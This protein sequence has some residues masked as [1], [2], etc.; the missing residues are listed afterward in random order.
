MAEPNKMETR[1]VL[2]LI[3]SMSVP[4]LISMFMQ[5]SYNFVDCM[6]VSWISEEALTAV[7]LA[8]PI[9]TLMIATSIGL[10]VGTNVLVANHLGRRQFDRANQ[11]AAN[12]IILTAAMGALITCV[13]LAVIEPF[14]S[15]FAEDPVIYEYGMQYM[16]VC[17]FMEVSNMVHIC[18]QK[19]IQGTGNMLAPMGFQ[20]AGVVLNYILDPVL[21]FGRGPFP[22]MGIR[23]AAVATVAGYTFSMLLAFWV[24]LCT[25]Q[26][27]RLSP[28]AF[29]ID[30]HIFRDIFVFGFPSFVMNAL[31]AAMTWFTNLFLAA[32][33]M[34]AVAFFGAY[35]KLQQV[36]VM[37]LNGLV[38]GCIPVMSYNYGAGNKPRLQQALRYGTVI[39]CLLTG[40][41]IVLLWALPRQ[42]LTIFR[43]SDA[44]M[45]FGVPAVRIMSTS[46]VFAAIITMI[47]S[48]MQSTKRVG[49]SLLMNALRQLVI[50]VPMMWLLSRF[51]G[52]DGIWWA[53]P[54]TETVTVLI[55][56]VIHKRHP[57]TMPQ[58]P[59]GGGA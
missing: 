28:R 10:G 17:A 48:Y 43:A 42:I 36:V 14:F 27:V 55:S 56:W 41:S 38:Q 31:G 59:A 30:F 13:V 46:Y 21:I 53:F 5:Y 25:P 33:S 12:A 15:A 39:A 34:T 52:M 9:T 16:R 26:R 8:F 51:W 32:W 4:P 24:L 20:I 54:V 1:P 22:A 50:L 6:F 7:S 40:A 23:G 58:G 49:Y 37:T 44:M 18:I 19:I 3:I 57:V 47:A 45:A 2:P 11:I 35:F 29:R